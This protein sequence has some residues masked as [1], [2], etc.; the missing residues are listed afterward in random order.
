MST[1]KR[2]CLWPRLVHNPCL[3][4]LFR[5]L[6][7]PSTIYFC[8]VEGTSWLPLMQVDQ[9]MVS[10]CEYQCESIQ[11]NH[12]FNHDRA[13]MNHYLPFV[14]LINRYPSHTQPSRLLQKHPP[15]QP[16]RA[17][18]IRATMILSH[19]LNDHH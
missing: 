15:L 17:A 6:L 5:K 10:A 4:Q 2:N 19:H 14:L 7:G 18:I 16:L 12:D 8:G 9:P 11:T 1:V 3:H 13:S